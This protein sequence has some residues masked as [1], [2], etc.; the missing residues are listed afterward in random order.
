MGAMPP[1]APIANDAILLLHASRLASL[2]LDERSATRQAAFVVG[3]GDVSMTFTKACASWL[4]PVSPVPELTI[5]GDALIFARNRVA[6]GGFEL[7]ASASNVSARF[8]QVLS[9]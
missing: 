2:R 6:S 5:P 7:R 9:H 1:N 4:C 3:V 8:E